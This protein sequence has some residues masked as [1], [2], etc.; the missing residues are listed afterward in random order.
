MD[1]PSTITCNIAF[2]IEGICSTEEFLK[3]IPGCKIAR[4]AN[5]DDNVY[6]VAILENNMYVENALLAFK[7]TELLEVTYDC[8]VRNMLEILKEFKGFLFLHNCIKNTTME[9]KFIVNWIR[10]VGDHQLT[11][12]EGCK[13]TIKPRELINVN[14]ENPRYYAT[15]KNTKKL[16][17]TPFLKYHSELLSHLKKEVDD[18][19]KQRKPIEP[20]EY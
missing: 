12:E 2:T 11:Q 10:T 20:F 1:V 16:P 6:K 3:K 7:T 13:M 5:N 15:T 17:A 14:F 8:N 9:W 19:I 18:L 4:T